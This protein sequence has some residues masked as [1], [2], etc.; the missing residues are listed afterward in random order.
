MRI[1][2]LADILINMSGKSKLVKEARL[3]NMIFLYALINHQF[4]I[5]IFESLKGEM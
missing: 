4:I 1:R 5:G 2:K 3:I